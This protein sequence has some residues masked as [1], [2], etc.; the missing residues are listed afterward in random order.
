M[1]LG[2]GGKDLQGCIYCSIILEML[3]FCVIS[4]L[5]FSILVVF[6]LYIYAYLL[7]FFSRTI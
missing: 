3:F 7:F 5:R 1:F 6:L 2:E 4:L